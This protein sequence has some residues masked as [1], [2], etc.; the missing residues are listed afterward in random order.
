VI[1]LATTW[2]LVGATTIGLLARLAR[3]VRAVRVADALTVPALRRLLQASVG[4]S[5]ATGVVVSALPAGVAVASEPPAAVATDT[6][7]RSEGTTPPPLRLIAERG[8]ADAGPARERR[9]DTSAP[10]PLRRLD[11]AAAADPTRP[12]PEAEPAR[13]PLRPQP[14]GREVVLRH[15]ESNG[16]DGDAIGDV[17]TPAA[18][19]TIVGMPPD[20]AGS[21]EGAIAVAAGPNEHIVAAGESLWTIA[22]DVVARELGRPPTDPEVAGYWFE[23]MD[24]QRPFLADPDDPDLIFPGERVRLPRWTGGSGG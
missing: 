14:P 23:L 10:P 4:L 12:A 19:G 22:R 18:G 13:T 17:T 20:G 15:L 7:A 3:S 1:V 8:T 24:I 11:P 2:Y 5:L 16:P 21:A 6:F 9:V